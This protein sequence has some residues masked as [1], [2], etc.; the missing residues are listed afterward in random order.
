MKKSSLW[1]I[2]IVVLLGGFI[3]YKIS[4]SSG[5]EKQNEHAQ[6]GPQQQPPVPVTAIVLRP[7][8]LDNTIKSTGTIMAN[9]EVELHPEIAGRIT[10]MYIQ[11]GSHVNKGQLLIKINDADLQAQLEKQKYVLQLAANQLERDKKLLAKEGI[12]QSEYDIALSTYN[13]A[14]ADIDLTNAQIAKTEIHAPFNGIIGLRYVSEGSYVTVGTRI[15]SMQEIDPVKVDFSVP[16]KYM[17]LVK[18]G[19][20]VTFSVQGVKEL[21]HGNIMAIEPKI[22]LATRSVLLRA[23]CPNRDNKILPGAFA[24][25]TLILDK[26]NDALMAPTQSI[27]PVMKG[28]QVFVA[29][30]TKAVAA[31]I[32]VG[33]RNDS[34]IEVTG[35]LNPG[36]TIITTGLMYLKSGSKI[37]L[38]HVR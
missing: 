28:Q 18:K 2:L 37:K 20:P 25:V 32:E 27:V 10:H 1:I 22:D 12:S 33:A 26:T 11:E 6:A 5:K 30:G 31:N 36:D 17:T 4:S 16:E 21:F 19:D 24:Q 23:V 34:T 9:N 7:V 14:R 15:A 3:F 13:S 29:R 35:G 8:Q 38:T